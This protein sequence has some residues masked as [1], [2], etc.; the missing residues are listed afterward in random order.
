MEMGFLCTGSCIVKRVRWFCGSMLDTY[1]HKSESQRLDYSS[2]EYILYF[3]M[4]W[5]VGNQYVQFATLQRLSAV[6]LTGGAVTQR[7]RDCFRPAPVI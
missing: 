6:F 1:V 5:Y 7:P 4:L 3:S 2:N